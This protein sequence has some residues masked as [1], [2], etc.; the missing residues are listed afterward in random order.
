MGTIAGLS[1]QGLAL[2]DGATTLTLDPG[3]TTFAF[4][5]S[6]ASGAA[7]AVT[8]AAQP[9]P[10]LQSC[11]LGD[12]A[13]GR[14]PGANVSIAVECHASRWTDTLFSGG[15]VDYGAHYA[16]GAAAASTYLFILGYGDL[17]RGPDGNLYAADSGDTVIR[18]IAADGSTSTYAGVQQGVFHIGQDGPSATAKFQQ[19]AGLAFGPDGSLYVAD[20]SAIRKISA[21]GSTVSVFAGSNTAYGHADG[22]SA[23]ARFWGATALRF[24]PDGSLYVTDNGY[25]HGSWIRKVGPDGTVSTLAGSAIPG[26]AD[27]AGAAAAFLGPHALAFDGAGNLF[28]GDEFAIREVTPD[29]TVTTF[30]ANPHYRP[31]PNDPDSPNGAE[32]PNDQPADGFLFCS[33][34][35]MAV[36]AA[37]NLVVSDEY[38]GRLQ[39]VAPDGSVSTL[40]QG[41]VADDFE[42]DG[43][44]VDT[45]GS[46]LVANEDGNN[47]TRARVVRLVPQ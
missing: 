7:Y 47:A 16:D 41:S 36:D 33:T 23:T 10:R 46:L 32:C 40:F 15:S 4:P 8:I 1:S 35:G 25:S 45:D 5:E 28:V 31:D 44:L 42:P 26:T 29:G 27:G 34:H 20:N 19:P 37:G 21:D 17:V 12:G 43:L 30:A 2:S 38:G 24:G 11:T 18:R 14:I 13:S 39:L 3:A 22:D 6:F 9:M